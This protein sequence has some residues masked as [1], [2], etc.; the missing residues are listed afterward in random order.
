MI[1]PDWSGAPKW[2]QFV[3]MDSSGAW[4]W[5]AER[6]VLDV[7]LGIWCAGGHRTEAHKFQRWE[8]S[9]SAR[10]NASTAIRL[11]ESGK[12]Y[13]VT[14]D[15]WIAQGWHPETLVANGYAEPVP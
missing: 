12:A 15:D 10:G 3:A 6:P 11:T 8:D 14:L 5:Y 1:K 4:Y 13:G 9:L 7:N 2:A